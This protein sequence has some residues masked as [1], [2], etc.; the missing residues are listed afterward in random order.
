MNN[1]SF[2]CC[3]FAYRKYDTTAKVVKYFKYKNI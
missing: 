2:F 1:V 3:I